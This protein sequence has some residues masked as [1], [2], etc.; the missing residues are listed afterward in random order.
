MDE[1]VEVIGGKIVG[2]TDKTHVIRVDGRISW[3][4]SYEIV[5]EGRCGEKLMMV[6]EF[7]SF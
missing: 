7:Y 5:K 3:T 1:G 6:I 2:V 4:L